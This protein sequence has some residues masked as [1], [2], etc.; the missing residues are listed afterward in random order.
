MSGNEDNDKKIALDVQIRYKMIEKLSA[1]NQELKDEIIG[2]KETE[3]QLISVNKSLE[4]ALKVKTDFLSTLSHETRTPL[5]IILGYLQI[6]GDSSV[7]KEHAEYLDAIKIA[8]DG[9][10]GMIDQ[11]LNYSKLTSKEEMLNIAT[12]ELTDVVDEFKKLFKIKAIEKNLRY[13][14]LLDSEIPKVLVG[15]LSKLKQVLYNI[16]GNAIKYTDEGFVE[17]C[18]MCKIKSDKTLD[19]VLEVKD[20]GRGIAKEDLGKI[21]SKFTQLESSTKRTKSG[22]GLGLA[23]CK[24]IIELMEG[25]IDVDSVLGQG[26]VFKIEIPLKYKPN[27]PL[28]NNSVKVEP[29]KGLSILLAEDNLMNQRM[30]MIVLKMLGCTVTVANNGQEAVDL[31]VERSFDI[32]LMDLHMPILNGF[33]A[34]E[35]I[36]RM[37]IVTPIIAFSA[38]ILAE[39]QERIS[40]LGIAGFISKP[41]VIKDLSSSIQQVI[42]K[43]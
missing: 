1:I 27:K 15:D 26:T 19:L 5:N 35:Q 33:E 12:F 10:L 42:A 34:T 30:A 28:S 9:M 18:F 14:L 24:E 11:I 31:C 21:F 32:I 23:I 8:A 3:Q 4:K 43:A 20:S 17:V 25:T 38:D 36:T 2:H 40:E 41:F 37:G 22:V 6:L 16:I 29:L 39:T 13:K 7:G